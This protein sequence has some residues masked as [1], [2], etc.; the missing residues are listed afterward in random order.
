M[1]QN[2]AMDFMRETV[3]C[4]ID[5]ITETVDELLAWGV[6]GGYMIGR[7]VGVDVPIELP[8]GILAYYFIK[9]QG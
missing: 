2:D 6:V 5:F 8:A 4:A 7:F 3:A 1:D 9:H